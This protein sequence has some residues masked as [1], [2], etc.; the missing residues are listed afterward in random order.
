[1]RHATVLVILLT[2][3]TAAGPAPESLGNRIRV[4]IDGRGREPS[5]TTADYFLYLMVRGPDGRLH[6]TRIHAPETAESEGMSLVIGKHIEKL[7]ELP[8][9][10]LVE[11]LHGDPRCAEDIVLAPGYTLSFAPGSYY[12]YR[13]VDR[14]RTMHADRAAEIRLGMITADG[15][16]Y[17]ELEA[18]DGPPLERATDPPGWPL[19]DAK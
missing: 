16:R 3:C 11:T 6:A 13:I 1:M 14:T 4:R 18:A 7:C 15:S 2:G 9:V 8:K 17:L 5:I 12:A 19:T 10:E